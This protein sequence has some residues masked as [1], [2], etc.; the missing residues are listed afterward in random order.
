LKTPYVPPSHHLL[1]L[2]LQ[3][4]NAAQQSF[5]VRTAYVEALKDADFLTPLLNYT[6][7]I[8]GHSGGKPF[9]ASKLPFETYTLDSS[10]EDSTNPA[11]EVHF[12]LTHIYYL[13]LRHTPSLVKRWWTECKS[14]QKVRAAEEFT[15]KYMSPLLIERE[16]SSV[17]AWI[18]SHSGGGVG[19]RGSE[20]DE[21]TVKILK[22]LTIE[23]T[24]TYPIDDQS[25]EMRVRIPP[26]FPL[27]QVEVEGARRVGLTEGDFR[28]MQRASQTVIN[29]QSA[30]IID[31]LAL[32][33]KNL[34]LHFEGVAE[35]AICYS[36][37]AVTPDRKL[38]DKTCTTCRNKFH[39]TCLFKWFKSSN[40]ASCPLCESFPPPLVFA[41]FFSGM[42][43]CGW[44]GINRSDGIPDVLLKGP[45]NRFLIFL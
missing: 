9:D 15:K 22:A 8:L 19:V 6:F 2:I 25:M 11:R 26:T 10:L 14:R 45:T 44:D 20:E 27:R 32:F 12:L 41:L 4:T 39:G 28:Q 35:C 30:S 23:V 36:I 1:F 40:S 31:G 38:P 3:S 13:A 24:A 42:L 37:V 7:D 43:M 33:R 21:M 29:F 18:Q 17:Q 34:A 16:L 5:K